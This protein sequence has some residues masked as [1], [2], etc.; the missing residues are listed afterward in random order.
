MVRE[1]PVLI[2]DKSIQETRDRFDPDQGW[3]SLDFT[4][5]AFNASRP[6]SPSPRETRNAPRVIDANDPDSVLQDARPEMA[7]LVS[8][9]TRVGFVERINC[10]D[11]GRRSSVVVVYGRLAKRRKAVDGTLVDL[12]DDGL[13]MLSIDAAAFKALPDV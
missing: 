13:V 2:P 4:L 1:V 10:D 12:V 5:Q 9:G 7:V 8:N 11:R 6:W 3:T